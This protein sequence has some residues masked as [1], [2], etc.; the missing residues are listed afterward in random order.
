MGPRSACYAGYVQRVTAEGDLDEERTTAR[1]RVWARVRVV[2]RAR[3]RARRRFS[4]MKMEDGGHDVIGGHTYPS[5]ER[6]RQQQ[7]NTHCTQGIRTLASDLLRLYCVC[8]A[9]EKRVLI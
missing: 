5:P 3:A 6:F 9:S 8:R 7:S 1:P 4:E 2:V